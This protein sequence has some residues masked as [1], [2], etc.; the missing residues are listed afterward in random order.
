M[1]LDGQNPEK[2]TDGVITMFTIAHGKIYYINQSAQPIALSA[3]DL[4]TKQVKTLIEGDIQLFNVTKDA[5]FYTNADTSA[6][7]NAAPSYTLYRADLNGKLLDKPME[8]T[9]VYVLNAAPDRIYMLRAAKE[10]EDAGASPYIFA[11]NSYAFDD[12]QIIEKSLVRWPNVVSGVV[13]GQNQFG[14]I[15]RVPFDASAAPNLFDFIEEP[16]TNESEAETETAQ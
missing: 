7:A 15:G 9:N 11:S 13:V 6:G 14:Q 2:L 12:E 8:D 1:D 10:D 5:I 3:Y 4:K 16:P